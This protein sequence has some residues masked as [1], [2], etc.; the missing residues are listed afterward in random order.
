VTPD[1]GVH[2]TIGGGTPDM[3]IGRADADQ[4]GARPYVRR[5]AER[6]G[7]EAVYSALV[8]L[9]RRISERLT[10][11]L[12]PKRTDFPNYT[13]MRK[14][15]ETFRM[16]AM[17]L[18]VS[19]VPFA[20]PSMIASNISGVPASAY[21]SHEISNRRVDCPNTYATRRSFDNSSML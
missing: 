18:L 14:F 21:S 3:T 12:V 13:R 16:E 11:F 7:A 4:G 9:N 20:M 5:T 2:F 8:A 10:A 1:T 17:A 6:L 15:V 19:G